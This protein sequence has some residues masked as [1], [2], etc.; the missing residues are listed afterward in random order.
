VTIIEDVAAAANVSTATVSRSLRG[1]PGVSEPTRT[2]VVRIAEQLGYVPSS[3]ASGLASGRTMAMG[4]ML[5][6]IAHWYFSG[7]L[8]GIDRRLRSAGYDLVVFNLGGTG[9]NRERV[10][11][12]SIRRKRID[13]LV[14]MCMALTD[15]ER[16]ALAELDF[17]TIV[18]GGAV[19]GVRHVSIDDDAAAREAMEHLISLGHTRIAHLGGGGPYGID[20][21]VPRIRAHA[22]TSTLAAHGL[23]ARP[24]WSAI[25]NF[26]FAEG[27]RAALQ[28]LRASPERPTAIFCASDEMAFGAVKAAAELGIAVP[29]QLSVVGIDDHEFS[30]SMGL[31]T[32]RQE[33]KEQGAYAAGLLLAELD[34]APPVAVPKRQPHRLV[35]RTSTAPPA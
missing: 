11:N 9:V 3:A 32:V 10:F 20:F 19:E 5:P 17:P 35:V 2:R 6:L 24:E 4:V 12:R 16:T 30:E 14:V 1:L 25:G 13:A 28:L 34:G 21:E 18:V 29:Q 23:G 7:V 27:R 8:E 22:Y 26:T 33:P 31:T 15:S